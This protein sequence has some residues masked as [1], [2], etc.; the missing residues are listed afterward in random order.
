M[1]QKF[2]A[3][4]LPKNRQMARSWERERKSVSTSRSPTINIYSSKFTGNPL[5]DEQPRWLI[6]AKI[7]TTSCKFKGVKK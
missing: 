6:Q 7:F 4:V 2:E 5:L 1:T 3:M